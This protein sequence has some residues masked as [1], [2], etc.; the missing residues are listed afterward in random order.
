MAD[1]DIIMP[2]RVIT[3]IVLYVMHITI[4][5]ST[6]R[7]LCSLLTIGIKQL[8]QN[9][10]SFYFLGSAIF[11]LSALLLCGTM[12]LFVDYKY[13]LQNYLI[14]FC[15]TYPHLTAVLAILSTCSVMLASIDHCLLTSNSLGR[16]NCGMIRITHRLA[17]VSTIF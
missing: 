14:A 17:A 16:R 7:S 13:L 9:P 5:L 8:R 12:R 4:I 1:D 11:D 6:F 10:C 2:E 3:K 15:N